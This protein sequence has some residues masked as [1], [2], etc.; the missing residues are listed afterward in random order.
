MVTPTDYVACPIS[1]T[2]ALGTK[3]GDLLARLVITVGTSATSAVT[4]A[5]GNGAAIPIVPANAPIGVYYVEIGALSKVPTTPG[6]KVT[7]LAGS[8]VL[9]MG[10]FQ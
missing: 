4:L 5:D 8:T 10:R 9:A 2:T 3:T 6:W 7:T 1:A